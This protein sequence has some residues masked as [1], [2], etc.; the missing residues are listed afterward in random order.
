MLRGSFSRVGL[1]AV[2]SSGCA[3]IPQRIPASFV[4]DDGKTISAVFTVGTPALVD[5]QLSDGRRMTLPQ[6][7]SASG[8]R[9]A[10]SEQSVVFWNKGRTAF[11]EEAGHQTYS[12]CV[13][14]PDP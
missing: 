10:N 4:C 7:M 11:I 8:A 1:I 13:R 6:V 14:S 2:M 12:A 3:A 5:L 9:Y